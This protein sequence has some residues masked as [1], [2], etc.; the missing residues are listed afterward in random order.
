LSDERPLDKLLSLA[1]KNASGEFVC[2]SAAGEIH[3]YLQEGRIAW[4]TDSKH[5]FAFAA[6][7]RDAAGIDAHTFRDVVE[8]CRR[9]RLPLGETLVS[10]GLTTWEGVRASL[11]HQIDLAIAL[12][13]SAEAGQALFLPRA[14]ASYD[15]RLTFGIQDFVDAD[16]E[17]GSAPAPGS[18]PAPLS[19][20]GDLARQLRASV[21]GL[22]WVEVLDEDRIVDGD[23]ESDRPRLPS[24]LVRTTILDGADFAAIRSAQS[25][26][27]GLSLSRPK[28][29]WCRTSAGSTFG[30]VVSAVLSLTGTA[31]RGSDRASMRRDA[32]AWSIGESA[33]GA[34]ILSSFVDRAHDVLGAILLG[35]DAH[36][37]PV[38]GCGSSALPVETC[39]DAARRRRGCLDRTLVPILDGEGEL[40]SIGFYLRTMVTGEEHL[41]CFG[42]ELA[43]PGAETLWLF[44]DRRS[45]QGLGWAYLSSLTRALSRAPTGS[46]R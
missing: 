31:E 44:L 41:W 29:V 32:G 24:G 25:S 45:A 19:E 15:G 5:P 37:E 26:L 7:L 33:P 6:H 43:P 40:D 21:D 14:Y 28:S 23:P 13:S 16:R 46:A 34:P 9:E 8:E 20:R 1:A 27:V 12:L 30:A 42:A 22:A 36:D 2:A 38:A 10:L 4:A 35:G 17:R 3:V 39:V 11:A 18:G